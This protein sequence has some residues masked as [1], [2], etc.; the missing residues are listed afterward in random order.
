MID[1]LRNMTRRKM[2][3]GL[4]VL[5]I[6][7]GVFALT[8]MGA[9]A[10]KMNLLVAGGL[11]YYSGH[12]SVV[13]A[14]G[15]M[16]NM[17]IS[18]DRIPQIARIPG[19]AAVV[20]VV[21]VPLKTDGSMGLG[22]HDF[23]EGAAASQ[24]RYEKFPFAAA[25]GTIPPLDER[26]VI[27]V[28]SSLAREFKLHVGDTFKIR[29]RAFTVKAILQTTMTAPD[30]MVRMSLPD[31]QEIYV[32]DQPPML[33]AILKPGQVATVFNVYPKPGVSGDVLAARI[34]KAGISDIKVTSPSE[35]KKQFEQFSVTFNL[36][37]MGSAL[38]ALI[39]GALSV[40][41]TMAM[42]VAERVKEIGLK[43]AIGARTGQ[44]LREFLFEAAAIGLV[45]GLVGLGLGTLLVGGINGATVQSGTQIFE[46]TG[47][48]AIGT[49]IFA[50]V[51]GAVAGFFPALNA[52]RLNPVDAL[53]TE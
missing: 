39:V 43:K 37:V 7:I 35:A 5:G 1:I 11:D 42:S 44:V 50:T 34:K 14:G 21:D 40:L 47:R 20:P 22:V 45:G 31:A 30:S 8:V 16:G 2:R 28:G 10:E 41:N 53:R 6:V 15:G 46:V 9:M 27:A 49:L 32:H 17:P 24:N 12:V 33:R 48:L 23:I 3:T 36:I 52:A 18:T 26:G 38:I 4:T 29:G 19:V 13:E 51:L 25:Q